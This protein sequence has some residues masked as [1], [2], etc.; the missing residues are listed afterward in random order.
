MLRQLK[1]CV[2]GRIIDANAVANIQSCSNSGRCKKYQSPEEA[3][4]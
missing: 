4:L 1:D 3:M 2:N